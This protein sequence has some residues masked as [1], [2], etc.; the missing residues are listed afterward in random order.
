MKRKLKPA[1]A[2]GAQAIIETKMT[3]LRTLKKHPKN[4]RQGDVDAI[5]ASLREN[6][7]FR[8][9]AVNVGTHTG[10]P[11]EI[12]AGY[13]TWLALRKNGETEGLVSFVDVDND[14]GVRMMLADNKAGDKSTYRDDYVSELLQALPSLEGTGYTEAEMN[15]FIQDA[16]AAADEAVKTAKNTLTG[17]EEEE[18]ARET[19]DNDKFDDTESGAKD[20]A[21]IERQSE[22]I[23]GALTLKDALDIG[24]QTIFVGE[25]GIP[26]LRE[27]MLAQPS[28]V[29]A[30]LKA[31]A[32]SATKNWEDP[33]QWWLYNWKIDSTSGMNDISKV[34]VGFYAWDH[35]FDNWFVDPKKYVAKLINSGIETMLTPNWSQYTEQS[36][37]L[38]LW[39]LYRARYVGRYA[40]EAGVKIIPDINF[41]PL[42]DDFITGVILSTLPKKVPVIALQVQTVGV[43]QDNDQEFIDGYYANLQTILDTVKP[44][45]LLLYG[46]PESLAKFDENV[47]WKGKV[48]QIESRLVALGKQHAMRKKK[49][50][51]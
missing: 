27:D 16:E 9:I 17:I 32:G 18:A 31:W 43:G 11:N 1:A 4:P 35:Y 22:S 26:A 7:Q 49:A 8:A 28:D 25:W 2:R 13:H 36:M 51:I 6:G 29:P 3:P 34:I 46:K 19:K 45:L 47:T 23:S 37:T 39:A 5:A 42:C 44:K 15:T 10:R 33:E 40:Q 20:E 12:I 50:T 38:N 48:Q 30:N 21:R 14:T 41:P 24:D